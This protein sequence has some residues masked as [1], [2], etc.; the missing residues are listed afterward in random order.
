MLLL[1]LLLILLMLLL[2][3]FIVVAVAIMIFFVAASN[4]HHHLICQRFSVRSEGAAAYL[5]QKIQ[6]KKRKKAPTTTK[7]ICIQTTFVKYK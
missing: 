1:L 6:I 3:V 2:M 4:Y 7:D 5:W